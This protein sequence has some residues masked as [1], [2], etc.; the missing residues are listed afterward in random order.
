MCL[1]T[2]ETKRF[3]GRTKESFDFLGYTLLP[4]RKLRPS[5]TSMQRMLT[6]AARLYKR[7]GSGTSLWQYVKRLTQ[8]LWAKLDNLVTKKG[9]I[10]RYWIKVVTQIGMG[11]IPRPYGLMT[12]KFR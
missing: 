10:Y 8:W 12:H 3:V 7:E 4:G 11:R 1:K 2:H 6:R 9:S 5:S